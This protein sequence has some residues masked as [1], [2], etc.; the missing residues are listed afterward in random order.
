MRLVV[1]KVFFGFYLALFSLTFQGSQNP[2]SSQD[3]VADLN[4]VTN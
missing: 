4:R 3:L 2:G 1:Q